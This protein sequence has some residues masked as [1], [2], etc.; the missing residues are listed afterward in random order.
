VLR[1]HRRGSPVRAGASAAGSAPGSLG[2]QIAAVVDDQLDLPGGAV[3][4]GHRQVRVAQGG[5]GDR[6]GVDRVGPA[7]LPA[8]AAGAGHQPGQH[9]HHPM[10]GA[11]QVQLQAAGQAPAIL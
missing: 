6:F 4:L 2:D 8:A 5:Q 1:G 3:Q 11:E 7:R 9:P 10:P